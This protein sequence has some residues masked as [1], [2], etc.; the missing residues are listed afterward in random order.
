MQASWLHS[1]DDRSS[2]R[3]VKMRIRELGGLTLW[4]NQNLL[5]LKSWDGDG[6]GDC[7]GDGDGDGDG[8][9]VPCHNSPMHTG[10]IR[11]APFFKW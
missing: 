9:N 6:D 8:D 3:R 11:T 7:D 1:E 4:K 2:I 10:L 5:R